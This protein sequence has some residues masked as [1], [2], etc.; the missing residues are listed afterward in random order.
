MIEMNGIN[1]M[2]GWNKSLLVINV[3]KDRLYSETAFVFLLWMFF[4]SFVLLILDCIS[5]KLL[6]P[7][8]NFS[9]LPINTE[10]LDSKTLFN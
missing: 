2:N 8:Q 7:F 6:Y 4:V 3:D 5:V 10:V 1:D 9:S